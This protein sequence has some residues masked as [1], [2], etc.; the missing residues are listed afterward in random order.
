MVAAFTADSC[1]PILFFHGVFAGGQN[2][3]LWTGLGDITFDS[4][5]WLGNG[6]FTG[7]SGGDESDDISAQN[8]TIEL[9]GIPES[10]L[11]IVL[12]AAQGA[13]G[14]FYVGA[15]DD[16]G[17]LIPDPYLIFSG[18]MDTA[19]IK[20]S[21]DGAYIDI[22]YETKLV[23]LDRPKDFRYNQESQKIFWPNDKGF[24]YVVAANKINLFW[25]NKKK[26]N[27]RR[28]K[29]DRQKKRNTR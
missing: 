25:G 3:R 21:A 16:D 6:W 12:N 2:V 4:Q 13:P 11:A 15:L 18:K 19:T 14:D 9:S 1:Q 7:L 23:D 8:I 17:A 28:R 26:R 24:E 10:I 22:T 5:N 20:E 29:R 27:E